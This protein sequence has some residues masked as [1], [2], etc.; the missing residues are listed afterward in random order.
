MFQIG[1]S[2]NLNGC[3]SSWVR[4][5]LQKDYIQPEELIKCNAELYFLITTLKHCAKFS[6]IKFLFFCFTKCMK[7]WTYMDWSNC[8]QTLCDAWG[9][10]I[11]FPRDYILSYKIGFFHDY[12]C[13]KL[14][15]KF[16]HIK[17]Y[18]FCFS[19]DMKVWKLIG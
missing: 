15:A 18:F 13:L 5:S 3:I 19:I 14:C 10:R 2:S 8:F 4:V 6:L 16:S 7:A 17:F 11:K 1:K 12:V 9:H